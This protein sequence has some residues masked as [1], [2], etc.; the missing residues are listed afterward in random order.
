MANTSYRMG[1]ALKIEP[2]LS[3][4]FTGDG[5]AAKTI[6]RPVHRIPYEV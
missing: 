4:K 2:G 3:S 1:R 5:E 6:T